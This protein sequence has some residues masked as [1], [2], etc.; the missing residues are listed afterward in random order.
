MGRFERGNRLLDAVAEAVVDF[1]STKCAFDLVENL[2]ETIPIGGGD[3]R[4]VDQFLV[5]VGEDLLNLR[6][7]HAPMVSDRRAVAAL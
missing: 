1:V 3:G 6:A 7:G 4:M 5:E 2:A